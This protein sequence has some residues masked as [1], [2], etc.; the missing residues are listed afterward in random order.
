MSLPHVPIREVCEIKPKKQQ[1]KKQLENNDLVSFVPMEKLGVCNKVIDATGTRTLEA[2]YRGYT[3]FAENDVLLAKITPCFENGKLG[4]ATGLSNGVGFG[5]SEYIVLR[6]TE[7]LNPEYLFYFLSRDCFRK[8]GKAVMT[9]A[10][11]H[12]RVPEDFVANTKIPLPPLDEQK[13]IVQILDRTFASIDKTIENTENNLANARELFDSELNQSF[14]KMQEER[15]PL[16]NLMSISHGYAF[17]GPDFENS[18]DENKPIV[19]TPGNYA[20]SGT[21]KFTEKNTK[22]LSGSAPEG[23]LFEKGELTVVMTDLSSKMKILGLP[24][25]I[26]A[27]N[28]LHN[29]RIGRISLKES[30]EKVLP[31]FIYYFL[32][33]NATRDTIK[34][35]ST[36]TMVRHTA[37][38]RILSLA[39][40]VPNITSQS[41]IITTL[42]A[43]EEQCQA[44]E[45][46]ASEKIAALQ[47]LKQSILQKAFTGQLT[48]DFNKDEEVA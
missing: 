47:E 5:S 8:D 11:G 26:D 32:R 20:E 16:S 18:T 43:M 34:K 33:S 40:P 23:Y 21:L 22:R 10:V 37:P 14:S 19:L 46:I 9:G 38:K 31:R 27:D 45:Q 4:I 13:R 48:A 1:V 41:K 36:G 44:L 35:T 17:K 6:S 24:A 30:Q 3:Y 25:F 7:K 39:I 15:E 12:K 2:S 29:Q 42:D 28:I